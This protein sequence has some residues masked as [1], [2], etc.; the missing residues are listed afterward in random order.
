MKLKLPNVTLCLVESRSLELALF[1]IEKSSQQIE[2]GQ[3]ILF[4]DLSPPARSDILFKNIGHIGSAEDYSRFVCGEIWKHIETPFVLIT[5]WDGCV[6]NAAAWRDEFLEYDYLGAVWPQFTTCRVGN[7]GFSLRSRHLCEIVSPWAASLT[8]PEDVAI[9]RTWRGQ[10]ERQHGIRF[11]PEAV[12]ATF[13]FER[14]IHSRRDAFGFHGFFNFARV[15]GDEL[16]TVL[17]KV[18][19]SMLTGRDARELAWDLLSSGT[20]ERRRLGLRLWSRLL[21]EQR[22]E[23]PYW[24]GTLRHFRQLTDAILGRS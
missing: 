11:A 14:D 7:G 21:Q 23:W 19:A 4:T 9:C 18:P 13:A 10:L 17:K 16:E 24:K 5:Q 22:F 20:Y 3:V 2:F 8:E 12:A 1:S 15:F 6:I